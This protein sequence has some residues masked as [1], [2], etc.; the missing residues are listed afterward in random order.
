M[1]KVVCLLLTLSLVLA[2]CACG[3]DNISDK[4]GKNTQ[5]VNGYKEGDYI[6]FGSYEQDNNPSNGTEEIKWLILDIEDDKALVI[7]K[8]ALDAQPYHADGG[9]ITW[10]KCTLRRWLNDD[11]LNS[12]FSADE[13]QKIQ[14]T[15]V[16]A[17]DN[18][19][20]GTDAGDD[21]QDKIFLLSTSEAENYFDS[22]EARECKA[23]QYA[24][25][26]GCWINDYSDYYGN[27]DWWL[28][29]PGMGQFVAASVETDGSLSDG[30]IDGIGGH[31]GNDYY[32]V[33]PA[34]WIEME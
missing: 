28:R 11:F 7:S 18:E 25:D 14:I 21:T 15:M 32:A 31:V 20:C 10:R 24:I 4:D 8:Y 33:R 1:E 29:S 26:K 30:S 12:A 23:T 19:E 17:K 34:M 22:D 27:C 6:T 16:V 2:L 9:D 5:M 3:K 13:Q